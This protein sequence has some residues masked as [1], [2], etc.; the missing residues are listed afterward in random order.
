MEY[1][2]NLFNWQ[3]KWALPGAP[4]ALVQWVTPVQLGQPEEWVV[5]VGPVPRA[6]L[7][8]LDHLVELVV[9]VELVERAGLVR[10]VLL[11]ILVRR[12]QL[13][14][15]VGQETLAQQVPLEALAN[16]H[17]FEKMEEGS[18]F[19]YFKG[20]NGTKHCLRRFLDAPEELKR[21]VEALPANNQIGLLCIPQRKQA[22]YRRSPNPREFA[23][24]YLNR[25]QLD[26]RSKQL[27][28]TKYQRDLEKRFAE[29]VEF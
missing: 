2:W 10:R 24:S 18:P 12:V 4:E 27:P 16:K 29:G 13:V 1:G 11:A 9:R 21:A 20:H 22:A 5:V 15:L 23:T 14:D 3:A 28:R 17:F 7:E 25:S 8:P 6:L 26:T 19:E